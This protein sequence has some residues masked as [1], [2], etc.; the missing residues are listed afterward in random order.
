MKICSR[1]FGIYFS[2]FISLVILFSLAFRFSKFVVI[3]IFVVL[4]F[5][6]VVDGLTQ[7][8]GWRESNNSFRFI[9][10]VLAGVGSSFAAYYLVGI[11]FLF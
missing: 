1:C 9:T 10:G 7:Y 4:N 2:L 6:L 5:P 3:S 8:F 11:V